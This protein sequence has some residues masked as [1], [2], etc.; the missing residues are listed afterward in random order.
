MMPIDSNQ[1]PSPNMAAA[2]AA[3]ETDRAVRT[4]IFNQDVEYQMSV[5]LALVATDPAKWIYNHTADPSMEL[6]IL[7]KQ[8]A[9]FHDDE[10]AIGRIVKAVL[11]NRMRAV[12]EFA[13]SE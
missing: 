9:L 4:E 12:A 6:A 7:Y 1:F 3:H 5:E 8:I 11:D 13:V 2:C 10:A